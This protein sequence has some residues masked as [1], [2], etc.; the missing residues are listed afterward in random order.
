MT[1]RAEIESNQLRSLRCLLATVLEGNLFQRARLGPLNLQPARFELASLPSLPLTLKSDHVADQRTHPPFGT[2]LSSPL[3]HYTRF[4]QTSGTTGH[5]LRWLDTPASWNAMVQSW[6]R[7]FTA[8][9]VGES[10]RVLLAFSFGPFLGFWLAFEAAQRVGCLTLPGG[11]LSSLSRLRLLLENRATVLCCTPTYAIHLAGV[12][13]SNGIDLRASS[14]R[15]LMVAGE[16]GGSIPA[17]RQRLQA[18]WP[19]AEVFD[20][21]GMTEVGPVTFECP[22]RPGRLHVMEDAF[23]PEI[24][25]PT[26]L[27]PVPPGQVGELILTT[28]LRVASPQIRYRTGD[29]VRARPDPGPCECGL[30]E[31]A[32]EGGILGRCDDM[33]IIRGVNIYPSAIESIVREFEDVLEYQVVLS[34]GE[35][36]ASLAI[37]IELLPHGSSDTASRLEARLH[38]SLSLRIPVQTVPENTLPKS[39]M[40]AKRWIRA[41]DSAPSR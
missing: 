36:M 14:L 19:G 3:E 33:V 21:H 37:N 7:V 9:G 16:P 27:A 40:K 2:N 41:Q 30:W 20:H 32:L 34:Q 5:P 12:A 11:G 26:T 38:Q 15:R 39:E 13:Q 24:I 1:G 25:D 17:T 4:H 22:A 8:A 6:V 35:T 23:I 18:L 31:L 28:L 10:D 29:H